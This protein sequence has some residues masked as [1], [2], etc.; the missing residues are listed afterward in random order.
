MDDELSIR[1]ELTEYEKR[2]DDTV[3]TTAAAVVDGVVLLVRTLLWM[4]E[5]SRHNIIDLGRTIER[6]HHGAR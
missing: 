6:I 2:F 5:R 4:A 1:Q 3:G